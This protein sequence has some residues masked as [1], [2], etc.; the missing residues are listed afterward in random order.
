[1][2]TPDVDNRIKKQNVKLRRMQERLKLQTEK[3]A[4]MNVRKPGSFD[5]KTN[6]AKGLEH[7]EIL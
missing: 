7:H 1:M 4:Q 2:P 6:N 5:T 3:R